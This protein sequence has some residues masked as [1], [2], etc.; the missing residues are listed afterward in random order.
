[1][2]QKLYK[3]LLKVDFKQKVSTKV[4]YLLAGRQQY[5]FSF[6]QKDTFTCANIIPLRITADQPPLFNVT[7]NLLQ[8]VR[9]GSNYASYA[10]ALF[11]T[12]IPHVEKKRSMTMYDRWVF[13]DKFN[14]EDWNQDLK[15]HN[16]TK[17]R[18]LTKEWLTSISTLD[19]SIVPC[20]EKTNWII[21]SQ[22]GAC[23]RAQQQ[24]WVDGKLTAEEYAAEM[25]REWAA[26]ISGANDVEMWIEEF[27]EDSD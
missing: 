5:G 12:A 9:R 8:C 10:P 21:E 27:P 17:Y 22:Y 19:Q 25:D 24:F 23:M 4:R 11:E 14:P 16:G 13:P 18:Y 7:M 1:M 26:A 6:N 20:M 3:R 15:K 2:A